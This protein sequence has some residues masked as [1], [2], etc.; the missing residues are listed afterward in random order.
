M[1]N[2][3]QNFRIFSKQTVNFLLKDVL[4]LTQVKRQVLVYSL[5]DTDGKIRF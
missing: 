2:P 3:R 5:S 4:S 1:Q